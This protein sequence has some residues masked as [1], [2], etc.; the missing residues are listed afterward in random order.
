MALEL[1]KLEDKLMAGTLPE[2]PVPTGTPASPLPPEPSHPNTVSELPQATVGNSG[3]Q[4]QPVRCAQPGKL[5][6]G[7]IRP[8]TPSL[9][10]RTCAWGQARL[11]AWMGNMNNKAKGSHME[12]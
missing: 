4:T 5:P 6:Y 11:G 1:G 7:P 12:P 8:A 10:T 9:I 2:A 3:E